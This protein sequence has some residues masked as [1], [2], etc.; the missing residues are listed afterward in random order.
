MVTGGMREVRCR[1]PAPSYR[2]RLLPCCF[3][4]YIPPVDLETVIAEVAP[5]LLAYATVRTGG[6]STAE[7][8]A[9]D[10]LSALVVRWR[11]LGPPESPEAFVFAIARRR[12]AR[13]AARRA[14]LMPLDAVVAIRSGASAID[15]YE[16]RTELREVIRAMAHLRKSDRDLL[17]LRA[18]GGLP[19][20]QI[21]KFTRTYGA[22][23]HLR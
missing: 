22:G 12:A 15:T 8:V 1:V 11:R 2:R 17:L 7:D 19:L 4:R 21:A 18:A 16:R 6:R 9:Q 3:A 14:L 13:A 23:V 20:D 10:A 5:R